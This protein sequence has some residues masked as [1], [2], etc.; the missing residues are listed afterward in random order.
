MPPGSLIPDR[1]LTFSPDLAATI[2]LEEAILLQ[3]L[4][5]L[6]SGRPQTS[7][8]V[9]LS[10]F[11]RNFPFWEAP[12]IRELL[13]RLEALGIINV[14]HENQNADIMR[15]SAVAA[16]STPAADKPKAQAAPKQPSPSSQTSPRPYK[17]HEPSPERPF[18]QAAERHWQ[19]SEDLLD[20]LHLSHGINRQFRPRPILHPIV[21]SGSTCSALGDATKVSTQLLKLLRHPP[22]TRIGAPAMTPWTL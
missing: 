6:L 20:L 5:E 22:S 8:C 18:I 11:E 14:R 3:G 16:Q 7:Q 21:A 4:G 17:S 1:Q 15:I 19:P 9:A 13:A 10:E 12:K 2:G